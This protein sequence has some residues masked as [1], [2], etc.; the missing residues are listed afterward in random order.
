MSPSPGSAGAMRSKTITRSPPI[1]VSPARRPLESG[2]A[3]RTKR[4]GTRTSMRSPGSGAVA[5]TR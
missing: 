3:L 2:R 4:S 1:S 5:R